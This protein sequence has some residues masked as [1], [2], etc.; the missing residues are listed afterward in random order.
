M[1]HS[2]RGNIDPF[3][4]MDVMEKARK[5]EEN[6]RK[7]IHLEVG[8]PS[9]AIPFEAL[10]R[11][12]R[13]MER[14]PLGYTVALG[15][16]ELRKKISGLYGRWY[17]VDLD[18]ARVVIT[19][20][21]SGAFIL[22]FI[23]LFDVAARVGIGAPGYPS[24][25]QILK[26]L[27]MLPVDI[28]TSLENKFQPTKNDILSNS[29]DGL[30]VASPSNPSGTMLDQNELAELIETSN[31]VG[32]NFIS[33][34]IYHGIQYDKKAVSALE[35]TDQCYVINSFSKFFSMTGWR[36]GWMV[37]PED[38]IRLVERLAQNLFICPPHISQVAALEALSCENELSQYIEIYRKNRQIIMHEL[39]QIGFQNFAPPDGAFYFY[40][41]ISRYSDDSLSFCDDV[42]EEVGV[43]ITP[44]VDFDPERGNTT[45]RISY[46]RSTDEISE[47]INRL[48]NFM[49][50]RG[51]F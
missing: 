2:V 8:Q 29:L 50:K 49:K 22:S 5:A 40:V 12:S 17:N 23:S 45:I 44:G 37:V 39:P 10:K 33:D 13:I 26:S 24:Y 34:E 46:A 42:L 19:S 28:K 1:K 27:G 7:I 47:G 20:G 35:I 4:V 21:S 6:G 51:Y 41:D 11:T 25:R 15:L 16:P 30:L 3:I 32:A 18:P 38:H 9:T 36:V 43:A 31:S 48:G 14:N